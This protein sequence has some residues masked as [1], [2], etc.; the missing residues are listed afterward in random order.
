QVE[1]LAAEL[2]ADI[3]SERARWAI[4]TEWETTAA[5]MLDFIQQRPEIMRRHMIE[6]LGLSGTAQI[7]FQ[8]AAGES[9]WI[10]VNETEPQPLPWQ[11]VYFVDSTIRL[12]VVSAPGFIFAGW[13]GLPEGAT[14]VSD[15]I[16]WPVTGDA[17]LTP[18]FSP[19][20]APDF[21]IGDVIIS[22][23]HADD[24]GA[25]YGD[26]A[27]LVVRREGGA[28]LRGWRLTDNDTV[29]AT[30]EG[31]LIF[32]DDPLLAAVPD[33]SRIRVI[34]TPDGRNA[35]QFGEDGWR[36]GVLVLYVGNG[37]I[38]TDRD[39]WFNLGPNDNLALLAPGLTAD[40][41]DD[42]AVDLWSENTAV[43]PAF[44]GLPPH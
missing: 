20:V 3:P 30:D 12:Q 40:F 37:R 8:V 31:S 36:D 17:A 38:N 34:A 18:R 24:E 33:G 10:V 11:G 13:E 43:T 1:R 41:A 23:Y 25:I 35:T 5:H 22:A 21:Q 29:T 7:S 27:E 2:E 14:A 9:G 39:P 6:S 16:I 4:D 19:A 28:D 44:F 42:T 32:A 15:T 26:W